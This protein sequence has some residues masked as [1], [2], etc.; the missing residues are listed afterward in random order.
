M[1]CNRTP[2]KEEVLYSLIFPWH[3][4]TIFPFLSYNI[5]G[6]TCAVNV[7]PY[8]AGIFSVSNNMYYQSYSFSVLRFLDLVYN[9]IHEVSY[10]GRLQWTYWTITY[11]VY[12]DHYKTAH[13]K[14]AYTVD[15]LVLY[16]L[17][18]G[19]L[20][21]AVRVASRKIRFHFPYMGRWIWSLWGK[22]RLNEA[23]G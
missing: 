14:L 23:N 19:L 5:C 4:L 11:R 17:F 9:Y 7:S 6:L 20:Y 21:R 12:K 13:P 3:H 22:C 8:A 2:I 10:C 1:S 16:E 18:L 15:F